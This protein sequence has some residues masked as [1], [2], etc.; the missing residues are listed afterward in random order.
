VGKVL[1]KEELEAAHCWEADD[2]VPRRPEMTEFRRR[3]RYHQ[4]QWR[5]AQGHPIGS[6]PIAPKPG[7]GA[8]RLVGSRL[9]LAYARETGANFL[10]AGALDA[11]KARTSVKEPHQSFDRHRLWADL[12]WSTTMAFN[13]FGD[14][15]ADLGLADRAVHTWWPDAP[16]KVSDVRFEHSPG[17][18]DPA[19]IGN[20]SSFDAAFVLDLDDGTQGIVGID[21]KYHER[22]KA[23][24][25]KPR[26]LRR[27]LEVAERSDVFAPGATDAVKGRTE[28]AVMWLEHLLVL[29][30]LQHASGTWNWGRYVVVYP[31]G[32]KDFAEAC[33]RYRDLLADQST[34]SSMTVE[35]LLDADTLPAR[36]ATGLRKRY[37][38]ARR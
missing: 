26:N 20:L 29:S 9:P 19:Y 37:L 18:L 4:S 16:G 12:L 35:E 7:G 27:Y 3:L 5:E 15:P 30:M 38:P 22:R 36:T 32:N 23:E 2:R 11:A 25:P 28:L 8:V 1:S 33:N 34:F 10:T 21:T 31:T 13:L 6:Q 14:L 17:W 24:T